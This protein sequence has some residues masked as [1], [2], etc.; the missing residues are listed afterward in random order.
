MV[1]LCEELFLIHDRVD[2]SLLND[3]ALMHLFHSVELLL[4]FFLDLPDLAETASADH[5]VKHKV[6]LIRR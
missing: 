3:T 5:I 6:I 2:T 4:L 1:K